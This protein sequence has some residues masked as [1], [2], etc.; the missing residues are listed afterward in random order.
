MTRFSQK[1][2]ELCVLR[3]VY[4]VD[5]FDDVTASE[6]PDFLISRGDHH[7]CF[8]VEITEVFRSGSDARLNRLPG[9]VTHLFAGG[10]PK[11]KDDYEALAI[12]AVDVVNPDGTKHTGI[13]AI[14]SDTP[15]VNEYRRALVAAIEA[16]GTKR[17]HY[18]PAADHVNLIIR[19]NIAILVANKREDFSRL[20]LNDELEFAAL[21]SGFREVFLVTRIDGS[22]VYIPLNA[23]SLLSEYYMFG[24]AA[25]KCDPDDELELRD[26]PLVL[27][28]HFLK[29]RGCAPRIRR[30]P[31]GV[32]VFL[33]G[34]GVVAGPESGVA[35]RL[36]DGYPL[37]ASSRPLPPNEEDERLLSAVLR[38][39]DLLRQ[40]MVFTS[41]LAF[42]VREAIDGPPPSSSLD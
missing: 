26:D 33:G 8:G 31:E 28:A 42:D 3:S 37:P 30:E 23:L 34:A 39:Y 35:L 32:E 29:E 27:F 16:K 18:S 41:A 21:D 19:D 1:E 5:S 22:D 4:D 7:G 6:R 36:Y 25:I 12:Q 24:E 20:I 2:Y 11:H 40:D 17:V 9:Y 10:E 13:P 15:T 14:V 38:T